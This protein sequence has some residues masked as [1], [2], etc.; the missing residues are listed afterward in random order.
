MKQRSKELI[1]VQN[2]IENDRLNINAGFTELFTADFSRLIG[3]Y[4]EIQKKPELE[5]VR[6]RTGYRVEISFYSNR[7]K[8]FNQ[9]LDN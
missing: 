2:I 5:I 6:D 7:L 1:R 4:F 9:I 8:I 3:D